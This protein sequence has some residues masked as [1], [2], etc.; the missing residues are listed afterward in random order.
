MI[1]RMLI[2][3]SLL[4][5]ML[6]PTGDHAAL[7]SGDDLPT[8]TITILY[9]NTLSEPDLTAGWGFAALIEYGEHILLFDTG[10]DGQALLGNMA[11][12][13]IDPLDIEAIVLSHGHRDHTGGLSA[14]LA[15]GVQPEVYLLPSFPSSVKQRIAH[16]ATVIETV[17]NQLIIEG[18]FTTGEMGGET[19]EQ[20]IAIATDRG[21]VVLT[22]CAHPGIVAVVERIKE[23]S[24]QPVYLVLGGFHLG[25]TSL[26][27]IASI[28]QEFHRLG[29]GRVGPCHCTGEQAITAFVDAYGDNYVQIGTGT[30]III[31]PFTESAL[32]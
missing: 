23:T 27:E 30:I 6:I 13:G 7:S 28:V 8:L 32:G 29:V 15:T 25:D 5:L 3:L 24:V 11:A 26:A 19:P 12:L 1:T 21:L 4:T 20:A 14:L 9:E 22:G 17:P 31:E 10:A 16:T 2:I 18:I